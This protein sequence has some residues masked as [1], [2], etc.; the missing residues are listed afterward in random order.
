MAAAAQ[1]IRH[2]L[3]NYARDRR[4]QKRGGGWQRVPLTEWE[5]GGSSNF[6][7]SAWNGRVVA[8][9]AALERLAERNERQSRIVEC[10]FY[11]G[12]TVEQT[13]VALG[14]STATV[15]RGWAMARAWL[16]RELSADS[17]FREPT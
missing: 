11:A 17:A 16:H 3:I 6:D 15:T 7:D 1:A 10:R 8:L 2:I 14:V 5:V 9:D 13:A 4:T 12:M